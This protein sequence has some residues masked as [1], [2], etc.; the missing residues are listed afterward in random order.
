M[1]FIYFS[2]EHVTYKLLSLS[3]KAECVHLS[4]FCLLY[5][6]TWRVKLQLNNLDLIHLTNIA[7]EIRIGAISIINNNVQSISNIWC[8]EFTK[9]LLFIRLP[10]I[11]GDF[12][13]RRWINCQRTVRIILLSFCSQLLPKNTSHDEGGRRKMARDVRV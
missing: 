11:M 10:R 13:E 1:Y 2:N 8:L 12:G 7:I 3:N 6:K 5:L 4:L 9:K